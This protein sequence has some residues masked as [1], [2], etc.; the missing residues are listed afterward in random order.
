MA[1]FREWDSEEGP[2]C[3][4]AT[5]HS[6]WYVNTCEEAATDMWWN[7]FVRSKAP[8]TFCQRSSRYSV[9]SD[10]ANN[11]SS[12]S[13]W[14]VRLRFS[15]CIG[16]FWLDFLIS[17][18]SCTLK[19]E[20]LRPIVK[21]NAAPKHIHLYLWSCFPQALCMCVNSTFFCAKCRSK[22]HTM[23]NSQPHNS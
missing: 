14:G 1:F 7:S 8:H 13:L 16:G 20:R 18:S 12:E 22:N 10:N 2:R 4:C 6:T 11:S 23:N 21:I 15:A 17:T 5:Y 9:G 3:R 19:C